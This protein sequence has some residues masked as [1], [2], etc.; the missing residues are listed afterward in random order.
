[1][2]KRT[3][4]EILMDLVAEVRTYNALRDEEWEF[5]ETNGHREEWSDEVCDEHDDLI[6]KQLSSR[7]RVAGLIAEATGEE[8]VDF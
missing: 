6:A 3:D 8:E 4:R 2:N 7:R 5:D 1:M